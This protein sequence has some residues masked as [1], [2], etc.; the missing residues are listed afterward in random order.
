MID[1]I[2]ETVDYQQGSEGGAMEFLVLVNN[3]SP[4]AFL[5]FEALKELPGGQRLH[6]PPTAIP[7]ETAAILGTQQTVP[8]GWASSIVI[9]YD[10]R[11]TVSS[12]SLSME[13]RVNFATSNVAASSPSAI[14]A[15]P[16]THTMHY[17]QGEHG[18]SMVFLLAVHDSPVG[19]TM[20]FRA[21]QPNPGGAPIELPPCQVWGPDFVA[22]METYVDAGYASDIQFT[23]TPQGALPTG[24][25][26][27]LRVIANLLQEGQPIVRS[28]QYDQGDVGD[29]MEFNL[30]VKNGSP[31]AV[32]WFEAKEPNPG[33]EPIR[34]PPTTVPSP[35]FVAGIVRHVDAFYRTEI[36]YGYD[37]RGTP[38]SPDL[39]LLFRVNYVALA[40]PE[41]PF[42][43]TLAPGEDP[44][45]TLNVSLENPMITNLAQVVA[46]VDASSP[47]LNTLELKIHNP[48]TNPVVVVENTGGLTPEDPLP[49]ID[50]PYVGPRLDRL[51]VFFPYGPAAGQL[52]TNELAAG[53][54]LSPAPENN[55]WDVAKQSDSKVGVNWILFPKTQAI[56][57]PNESVRFL[58]TGILTYNPPG[59]LTHLNMKKQ[60]TGYAVETT[61]D[62]GV[63]LVE[64]NPKI[65]DFSTSANDVVAGT[66]VNLS[67]STWNVKYCAI[68][69]TDGLPANKQ[70][71]PQR[72]V[73][74][75]NFKLTATSARGASTPQ[76]LPVR[77]QDASIQ[78]FVADP[79]E[80]SRIGEAVKL[81]WATTSAVTL[82][83][84]PEVGNVCIDAAG[85]N[86][87]ERL[88]YPTTRTM[89]TL[90]ATGGPAPVTKSVTVFPMPVGW[91]KVTDGAPWDTRER[92]VLLAFNQ[93]LWF[94]G[95][96]TTSLD[97]PVY[98]SLD[99][100]TW[101][102]AKKNA[103]WTKRTYA[104]GAVFPANTPRMLFFGGEDGTTLFNDVWASS[105]GLQWDQ[106]SAAAAWSK[107]SKFGCIVFN[108]KLWLFGGW[109]GTNTLNDI[110]SSDDG[111]TW[112][113]AAQ[114][115]AWSPRSGFATVI[116]NG[117]LWILGGQLGAS[118]YSVT[119]EFWRSSDGITW[120]QAPQAPWGA[121][122][123]AAAESFGKY[124]YLFDGFTGSTA[125]DELWRL[126]IRIEKGVEIFEWTSLPTPRMNESAAMASVKF[127][128]GAWLAGGW[129]APDG[130]RAPNRTVWLYSPGT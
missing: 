14:E 105:D 32:I 106:I 52:T 77:V 76:F 56:M 29:L 107:R 18:G 30:F 74:T 55:K 66:T 16:I 13:L 124:L 71:F 110:W 40:E 63:S 91:K 111:V 121:R 116:F 73:A 102:I 67:W 38:V 70:N 89:Y 109:D 15:T 2:R 43:E 44:S 59:S 82:D 103:P 90:T 46:S 98:T 39:D 72:L 26:I 37:P 47:V 57:N 118:P 125:T 27:E 112:T 80:G 31:G 88:V 114:P 128:G 127:F 7:R 65:L 86:T 126:N 78:S 95:G 108:G 48:S 24:F 12:P 120:T 1:V 36:V 49:P 113:K 69:S 68:D 35:G 93:S 83:I 87:G 23:F 60:I 84:A 81:T 79:P 42:R 104:G 58:F 101:T 123:L 64:G 34:L 11:G 61:T 129:S 75:K 41:V 20:S 10:P 119:S 130:V 96:G 28:L 4:G 92:P 8:A 51:Y 94:M 17:E 117:E 115:A 50:Q 53:I 85:C 100:A 6:L 33:G 45:L 99:G 5:S 19:S 21:L 3:A 122:T 25:R 54:T 62:T 22:G 97:N 9:T